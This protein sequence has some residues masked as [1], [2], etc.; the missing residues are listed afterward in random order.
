MNG[1]GLPNNCEI[2]NLCLQERHLERRRKEAGAKAED[3]PSNKLSR[4]IAA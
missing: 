2:L 1:L 4:K 3:R